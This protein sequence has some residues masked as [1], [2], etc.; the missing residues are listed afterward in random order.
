MSPTLRLHLLAMIEVL[1]AEGD[2][3]F[4]ISATFEHPDG[5][6]VLGSMVGATAADTDTAGAAILATIQ[7][8][9][10]PVTDIWFVLEGMASIIGPLRDKSVEEA[11]AETGDLVPSNDPMAVPVLLGFG[12]DGPGQQPRSFVIVL[13]R[14]DDGTVT[15]DLDAIKWGDAIHPGDTRMGSFGERALQEL[16]KGW[17]PMVGGWIGSYD[18]LQVIP[19]M[20]LTPINVVLGPDVNYTHLKED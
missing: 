12:V 15:G 14:A 16:A 5:G 1:R 19:T 18:L 2:T 7:S 9:A 8:S 4:Q 20:P 3:P 11:I 10:K 13:G 6:Y 17:E